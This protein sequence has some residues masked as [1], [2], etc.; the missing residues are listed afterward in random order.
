MIVDV[1]FTPVEASAERIEGRTLVVID[2]FRATSCICAAIENGAARLIPTT[3]VEQSLAMRDKLRLS[4]HRVLLGG[5]RKMELIDGFDLDNSPRSYMRDD[6]HGAS[7]VMTTTNGTRSI[8][9]ASAHG[10][11][12]V[13]IGSLL[14]GRAAAKRAAESLG[15][16]VLFCSGRQDR[17]TTEDAICAGYMVRVIQEGWQ[18][19]TT[20][21]AWAVADLYDRYKDNLRV[22]LR[23]CEHYNR[24]IS[25][26]L[27]DD[28][29]YCL[30]RDIFTT[31]PRLVD[32]SITL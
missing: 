10:A 9:L 14:N 13:L 6:V 3:T 24:I 25:H 2:V 26:G 8:E 18:C 7:V 28:V 22:P 31:V 12:E 1:I 30:Q 11:R 21:A 15:D 32:G 23:H 5:E 17:F 27:A 4:G 19:E 29:D 20:D 16:V